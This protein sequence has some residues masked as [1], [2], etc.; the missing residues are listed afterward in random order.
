MFCK[1][2]VLNKS[3]P[4]DITHVR[5]LPGVVSLMLS[6]TT[7]SEG[8][9]LVVH[10]LMG[11][12]RGV[13]NKSFPT[14]TARTGFCTSVNSLVLSKCGMAITT[15]ITLKTLTRSVSFVALEMVKEACFL[16]KGLATLS[17]VVVLFS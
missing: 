14:L 1:T 10:F 6:K 15:F 8:F 9:F 11:N 3:F 2:S 17:T 7:L 4:T 5:L 12:K 13:I 16:A